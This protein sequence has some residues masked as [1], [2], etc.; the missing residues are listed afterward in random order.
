M[1]E[2]SGHTAEEHAGQEIPFTKEG[3]AH[4]LHLSCTP[5]NVNTW[6]NGA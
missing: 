3:H 6:N 5:L 2:W 1:G 4:H